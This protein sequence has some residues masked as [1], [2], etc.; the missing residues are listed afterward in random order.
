MM[1]NLLMLSDIMLSNPKAILEEEGF[2]VRWFMAV[3]GQ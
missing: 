3:T 1:T 2:K